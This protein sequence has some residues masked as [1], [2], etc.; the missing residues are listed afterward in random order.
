MYIH[1]FWWTK[2]HEAWKTCFFHFIFQ[3]SVILNQLDCRWLNCHYLQVVVH[4]WEDLIVTYV[5]LALVVTSYSFEGC[6]LLPLPTLE[7]LNPIL[8]FCDASIS[9]VSFSFSSAAMVK[10]ANSS[11]AGKRSQVIRFQEKG[12]VNNACMANSHGIKD[13]L[14]PFYHDNWAKIPR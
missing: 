11:T 12:R 5:E 13:N 4:I 7:D 14:V 3:S 1:L 2:H 6:V 8:R 10:S 9:T